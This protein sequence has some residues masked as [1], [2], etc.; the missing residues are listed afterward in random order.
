MTVDRARVLIE[1]W[2]HANTDI[3][4]ATH[5]GA[6]QQLPD[7]S[8]QREGVQMSTTSATYVHNLHWQRSSQGCFKCNVDAGFSVAA[9]RTSI[10][11]CVRDDED[12]F[13]LAKTIN[14][15]VVHQVHVGEAL[16]QYH[17]MEWLS[18]MLFNKD[19]VSEFGHIIAACQSLFTNQFTN[20][21]VEFTR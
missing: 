19:D 17:A 20:S 7:S 5:Q 13:V 10:D 9:N 12:A 18:D 8:L 1:E 2:Q 15:H 14:F 16:G 11:I 21:R 3:L 4:A 6:H